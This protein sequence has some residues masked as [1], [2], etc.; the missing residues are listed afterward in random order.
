VRR[1]ATAG[2]TSAGIAQADGVGQAV[3]AAAL[4]VA[5][6]VALDQ[7][8]IDAQLL[9]ILVT[10]VVASAFASAGLAFGI[11]A[12]TTVSN[13][14]AA[15]YVSQSYAVGQ[16]VRIGDIEGEIVQL[17]PTAVALSTIDGRV[18]VPAKRFS[19][20]ASTLLMEGA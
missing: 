20:E 11:G 18:L 12:N 14:V 1:A 7:I 17:M 15:Y 19:E 2:A 10:V 9:V 8:G 3:Q 4:L 6:V 13:I 5:I 16:Q